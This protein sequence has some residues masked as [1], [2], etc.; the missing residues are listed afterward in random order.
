MMA[1]PYA[2]YAVLGGLLV[3]T[4]FS[5]LLLVADSR[6]WH[7]SE[8]YV[9]TV[10]NEK[11]TIAIAVQLLSHSLGLFQVCALCTVISLSF[12]RH[13]S[14]SPFSL[15]SLRFVSSAFALRFDWNLPVG[16]LVPLILFIGFSVVPAAV[17]S[18]A[19]TPNVVP[20][21]TTVPFSVPAIG[22]VNSSLE[23]PLKVASFHN[24]LSRLSLL[25]SAALSSSVSSIP[26][27]KNE[28]ATVCTKLD[29]SGYSFIGRGYGTGGSVGLVQ[30][31]GVQTPLAYSFVEASLEA[32]VECAVNKTS[33]FRLNFIKDYDGVEL[34]VDVGN[35]TLPEGLN[36]CDK[37]NATLCGYGFGELHQVQCRLGFTAREF[38]VEVDNTGRT[39]S[40]FPQK[41]IDW[42]SYANALLTEL[43]A[44]HSYM[45]ALDSAFGGSQLGHAIRSNID[46]LHAYRNQTTFNETTML[47]AIE[48]FIADVMDNS[49]LSFSQSRYFGR[50]EQRIVEADVVRNVVVYGEKRFIYATIVLHFVV[51]SICVIEA[52]RTRFWNGL[53][54]L[55][56]LDMASVAVAASLGGTKLA[57][58]V[59]NL[60]MGEVLMSRKRGAATD[61]TGAVT[62][63]LR[64]MDG[65]MCAIE[66]ADQILMGNVDASEHGGMGKGRKYMAVSG[67][68]MS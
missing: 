22:T 13:A 11:P 24:C 26:G 54:N 47:N 43:A 44:E 55:D 65:A 39:I 59:Q 36:A 15:N 60:G 31:P 33:E 64:G 32:K 34:Y 21:N 17:W 57:A 45:S 18:G 2:A 29:R 10:T 25:G 67:F 23:N 53:R 14:V 50:K 40:V 9:E 5:V 37:G 41:H 66:P 4:V 27:R 30:L 68:E 7:S 35:G 1:R 48:D 52:V 3:P 6:G 8:G 19:I 63:R 62:V 51:L 49:L 46:I 42:P 12:Q 16:F 20:R 61:I 38:R 58:H 56:L 28:K